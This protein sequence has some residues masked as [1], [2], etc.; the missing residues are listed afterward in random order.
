MID[1]NKFFYEI[2][3][4]ICGSLDLS[5]AAFRTLRFIYE[6]MPAEELVISLFDEATQ[7]YRIIVHS[8]LTESLLIDSTVELSSAAWSLVR[9]F[10]KST[11]KIVDSD[12]DPV[13]S[14]ILKNQ[15]IAPS[16][17][18]IIP[19][20][21]DTSF[22]G[23]VLLIARERRAF[24]KED[25]DLL[26]I[27]SKPFG[28]ALSNSLTYLELQAQKKATEDENRA[29]RS[30]DDSSRIILGKTGGLKNVFDALEAV[31]P[32]DCPILL[33]GETGTG[34]GLIASAIHTASPRFDRPFI[35]MDCSATS[36]DLTDLELFGSHNSVQPYAGRLERAYGGTLFLAE[37]HCLPMQSQH[38]LAEFLRSN[39]NRIRLICSTNKN[40]SDLVKAGLF[41]EDLYYKISTSPIL[42]PP[43]RKRREDILLLAEYMIDQKIKEMGL[44]QIPKLTK[45]DADKLLNYRW[46]GN[47]SELKSVIDQAVIACKGK[48]LNIEPYLS[49][50]V[51]PD[52][53]N[54]NDAMTRT[55]HAAL[56]QCNGK[57]SGPKGA[58]ALLGINPSTLRSRMKKL[59]IKVERV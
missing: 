21:L 45:K 4:R 58:A 36:G 59:G 2:T 42:I 33:T 39:P 20:N 56:E 9:R 8:T 54:L 18:I 22:I 44:K 51:P 3:T 52:T 25:A 31:S 17:C 26:S 41:R 19:L 11:V 15:N 57:I 55:I 48:T 49:T 47:V 37:V 32:L 24:S 46:P 10:D 28:I 12:N 6:V 13:V 43:L 38:K 14:A 16:N 40:L 34:K 27:T 5:K 23:V 30:L 53:L 29:L 1:K 50:Q 35:K 7:R